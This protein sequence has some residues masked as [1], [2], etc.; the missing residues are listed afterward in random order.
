MHG[1]EAERVIAN[2]GADIP[3]GSELRNA[4]A[5]G[6]V[7]LDVKSSVEHIEPDAVGV[8]SEEQLASLERP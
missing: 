6:A 1:C 4:A 2:M 3:D 5:Q 7:Q 8:A